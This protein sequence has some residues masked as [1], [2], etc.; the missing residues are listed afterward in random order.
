MNLISERQFSLGYEKAAA[1]RFLQKPFQ[2]CLCPDASAGISALSAN[3][4]S[5]RQEAIYQRH[6]DQ[7]SALQSLRSTTTLN[8][9]EI[10]I[11]SREVMRLVTLI[12]Q[13]TVMA[14]LMKKKLA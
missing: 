13:E 11:H 3:E 6:A 14:S 4:R 5:P 12:K 1:E 8:L 2:L 10:E 7:Y 9:K